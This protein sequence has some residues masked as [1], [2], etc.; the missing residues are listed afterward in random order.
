MKECRPKRIK[1][2]LIRFSDSFMDI[3]STV[4]NHQSTAT[5]EC[6]KVGRPRQSNVDAFNRQI[7]QDI[8]TYLFLTQNKGRPG[9]PDYEYFHVF[10]GRV[11]CFKMK[12]NDFRNIIKKKSICTQ[13]FGFELTE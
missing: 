6:M 12:P 5:G 10:T 1:H 8:S 7:E 9:K 11:L 13:V 4:E 2:L 3:E